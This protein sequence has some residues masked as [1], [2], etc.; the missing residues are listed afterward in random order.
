MQTQMQSVVVDGDRSV[1]EDVEKGV[2]EED[3]ECEEDEG[4]E[5]AVEA[6]GEDFSQEFAD[7]GL[8]PG[9]PARPIRSTSDVPMTP[10]TPTQARSRAP[11]TPRTAKS[12]K[13]TAAQTPRPKDKEKR[14]RKKK[15]RKSEAL[16]LAA[17]NNEQAAL[18]AL[19]SNHILHLRLRKKYYTEGLNF[20]R[21]VE[22]AMGI[23][24]QLLVSTSKA[25]VL[26]SMEF[27]RVAHEYQFESAQVSC[28]LLKMPAHLVD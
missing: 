7:A 24:S 26:E 15:A 5:T 8:P 25:E 6:D 28:P 4:D 16:D 13:S 2:E 23:L 10:Q 11:K 1:L 14:K 21:Q 9:T 3:E 20:I 17:L 27:F 22:G 19:E 12:T 18:A